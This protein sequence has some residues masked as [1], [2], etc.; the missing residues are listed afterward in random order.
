ML[1]V[2]SI[3]IIVLSLV[4]PFASKTLRK[5]HVKNAHVQ[6]ANM[7]QTASMRSSLIE[8]PAY[9]VFFYVH[10]ETNRQ[11]G[12]YIKWRGY[13]DQVT[14]EEKYLDVVDRFEIDKDNSPWSLKMDNFVRVAPVSVLSWEDEDII[15]DD[16]FKSPH[17]NF[18]V[19]VFSDNRLSPFPVLIEDIDAD[20]DDL[21]DVTSLPVIDKLGE[22]P[23]V[24]DDMLEA[25]IKGEKSRLKFYSEDGIIVYD[26]SVYQDMLIGDRARF[27][28]N[29][30]VS[31]IFFDRQGRIIK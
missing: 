24:V 16:Y 23:G 30:Y 19:I 29:N 15:N 2:I 25:K 27:I 17:R 26:E 18:F 5:A 9:G 12:V 14:K 31:T 22:T 10:P 28:K 11:M 8:F 20:N 4:A 13:P 21:G 6:L 1:V 3:I 7:L